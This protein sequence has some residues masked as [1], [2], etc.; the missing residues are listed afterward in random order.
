[1]NRYLR[2]QTLPQVGADGQA[3]LAAARVLVI[4]AGGLGCPALQYLCGAGIGTIILV[5]PDVVERTNLHRQPLFNETMLGQAKA[6]AAKNVLQHLNPEVNV[7]THITTLDPDNAPLL[8]SNADIVLD[9]ADSYAAS[10]IMS[11]VCLQMKKPLISASA[12]GLSGYVGGFCGSAPSLRAVFPDL[13]RNSATCATA[14]VMG[15]VVG[16]IGSIQAQMALTVLLGIS[17]S[18]LGQ[19]VSIRFDTF[20]FNDFRFD[21]A[22][23]PDK[24]PFSF[25]SRQK[26]AADDLI[27]ELRGEDE[28]PIPAHPEAVRASITTFEQQKITPELGQRVVICCRSGL[29]AWRAASALQQYWKGSIAL[30]ALGDVIADTENSL[31]K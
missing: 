11:D 4:G 19:L 25:I 29:R 17:P 7:E 26:L 12:L 20:N 10:Y 28:A 27:I 2:Q 30:V 22:A 1:M 23:E 13:P 18:P 9:C 14:G 3:S 21:Q 24:T 8:I 15:P 6:V 16:T 5:D 31:H